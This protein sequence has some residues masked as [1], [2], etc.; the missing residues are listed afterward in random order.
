MFEAL[1]KDFSFPEAEK[2]VLEFWGKNDIF[3]KSI[4]LREGSRPFVF[5]EGPPT[6]NG[7]PGIH[8]V[9]ARTIKDTVCRYQTMRGLQ[10]A[11]KAGWDTHGLPVEIEVE[12]QLGLESKAKI[13]AYGIEKFNQQCRESVFRYL[14]EWNNLTTRIGYWLDLEHPYVTLDRDY[15]E[16]VWWILAQFFNRGLLYEGHKIVPFCPR[17]ET[18]L[19]S[20]EVAQGY[21]EVDDPSAF[22]TM[23]LE[24][25][26][27][28]SF[29]VWTTT[30][31]TLISNTA[32]AVA[33]DSEYVTVQKDGRKLILA[34]ALAQQVLGGEFEILDRCKGTALA[35]KRYRPLFDFFADQADR[36]YFVITADFVSMDE[37][38]GIV[39]MAPAFGAD[40]Y[41]AGK[42]HNLPVFQPVNINGTF[43]ER[44][45]PYAGMFVKQADPRITAD[46]H[47]AGR[48]FRSEKYRHNYPF[49]WRCDS[50]L[51]HYARKSWYIKTS[52]FRNDLLAANQK[53]SWYPP[54]IGA[55]RFGEWLENNVDWALSR[56]RFWGTP[57]NIWVCE[58]CGNK[59]AVDSVA[60]LREKGDNLPDPIDLHRP[61]VDQVTLRCSCGGT[62]RRVPEVI[63]VWFDSGAMPF[64]QWHYPF[65]HQDDF[66]TLF[67][68]AFISEAVDQT[69]GWFY[70]LLA[71]STLLRNEPS[72][73]NC[74]VMEFVVD[75]DGQKMS[76]SRGNA[77]DPWEAVG[78]H[79]ADAL[80][81]YMLSVSQ[82]WLATRYDLATVGEVK[83]RFFDTWK[84]TYAFFALYA[85]IDGL[86][87][88]QIID[89]PPSPVTIDRWLLS[90]M[91]T[92]TRL[93][94]EAF[95]NYDLTKATRALADFLV[96]DVSNWYVRLNRRRFWAG[97]LGEDKLDAYAT[98]YRVLMTIGRL[99]APVAPFFS[100]YIFRLL[101]AGSARQP[102]SV[103]LTDFPRSD[104]AHID[105][106]LELTVAAVQRIVS[107]GRA[108]R[109]K[110]NIKVRQPV[111]DIVVVLAPGID[112]GL[113][114]NVTADIRGELNVK[115]VDFRQSGEGFLRVT[116]KPNFAKIGRRVGPK[117]KALTA[118]LA[119][120]PVEQAATFRDSGRLD[121][122]VDGETF[123]FEGDDLAV[124]V[125]GP[126][127]YH[128]EA[129]G[130]YA[131]G[132]NTILT[133]ELVTEGYYRELINKIQN[134]RKAS[135]LAVTDRI[136]LSIRTTPPVW[137]AVETFKERIITETLCDELG[138]N[139]N[140]QFST[141]LKLNGEPTVLSLEVTGR[142]GR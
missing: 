74:L 16:T 131:V 98:L 105:D 70:S 57:L 132:L 101:T 142:P 54:E 47:K 128:V 3:K 89:R 36:A 94:G 20:H 13:E 87:A 33:A 137:L 4:S 139:G 124:T 93:V 138:R 69:R 49:C 62:M 10:V 9:L 81:W 110:T 75:K 5:F 104:T 111:A 48:L 72:F 17:C 35:G 66:D 7:K 56:E 52:E 26:P 38:T 86:H 123:V 18:G 79:G 120:L 99:S 12:K 83:N 31:W 61:Y 77:A 135:G 127:G 108:A 29:L 59:T 27:D 122:E 15:M 109:V 85:G 30:P 106:Q 80:R 53:I 39:H 118:V 64:A 76:K 107:L 21:A 32:L 91:H 55:G 78:A 95:D 60:M 24:E 19:S 46:L 11:R 97:G 65:E 115:Q 129:D 141:E 68:A 88:G 140:L 63:D 2:A 113:L 84:N 22:V 6:A 125:S 133:G 58:T 134:L 40:D 136:R 82:P 25:D 112:H 100:E 43:S 130:G 37:G 117:M 116:V 102:E 67:P 34:E 1:P 114:E 73:L 42:K 44:I 119:G 8:H 50:P 23:S 92:V 41:E 103:H 126:E 14:E 28:I 71:I 90:R 45:T 51:I 121:L 96:D